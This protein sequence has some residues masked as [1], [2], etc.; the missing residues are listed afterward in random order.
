M[1]RQFK[2][3]Y[4]YTNPITNELLLE[5]PNKQYESGEEIEVNDVILYAFKVNYNTPDGETEETLSL[6]LISLCEREFNRYEELYTIMPG[7]FNPFLN[8]PILV[9][10]GGEEKYNKMRNAYLKKLDD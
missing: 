8:F 4:E 6:D 9:E 7:G 3:Q 2:Q 5:L 10:K 1:K